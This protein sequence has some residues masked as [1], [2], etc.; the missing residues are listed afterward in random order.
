M[1][2]TGMDTI[3]FRILCY[4]ILTFCIMDIL[5]WVFLNWIDNEKVIFILCILIQ[6]VLTCKMQFAWVWGA[7]NSICFILNAF[8]FQLTE[9]YSVYYFFSSWY[10]F[11][12]DIWKIALCLYSIFF[13]GLAWEYYKKRKSKKT[14][15]DMDITKES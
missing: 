2:K 15:S 9:L 5:P 6:T 7:V 3:G 1:N 8:V 4:L 10:F 14:N 11:F 12:H 13:I